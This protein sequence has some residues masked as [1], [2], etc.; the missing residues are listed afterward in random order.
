[1][2]NFMDQARPYMDDPRFAR[3]DYR[4]Q[5]EIDNLD[6]YIQYRT[7]GSKNTTVYLDNYDPE[8]E[9]FNEEESALR[10]KMSIIHGGTTDDVDS[11]I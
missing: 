1:M 7:T 4:Y 10:A 6:A 11:H 2:D 8:V 9:E 5:E 3:F